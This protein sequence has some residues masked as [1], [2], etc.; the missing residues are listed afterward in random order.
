MSFVSQHDEFTANALAHIEASVA[1]NLTAARNQAADNHG[2]VLNALRSMFELLKSTQGPQPSNAAAAGI[3]ALLLSPTVTGSSTQMRPVPPVASRGGQEDLLSQQVVAESTVV[4]QQQAPG[5]HQ[6]NLPRR[7]LLP[8][9]RAALQA[10]GTNP[11][12][13][14]VDSIKSVMNIKDL[15]AAWTQSSF[16]GEQ[17]PMSWKQ[18]ET[19]Y[20]ESKTDEI[21][22]AYLS[23]RRGAGGD[24]LGK[25]KHIIFEIESNT[26]ARSLTETLIERMEVERGGQALHKYNKICKDKRV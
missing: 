18:M 25:R 16:N 2:Q 19:L 1:A 5:R 24:M 14:F 8:S 21:P 4:P 6:D 26:D 15:W 11:V 3:M 23:W 7:P 12:Q 13:G 9:E 22:P 17:L 10:T 20:K